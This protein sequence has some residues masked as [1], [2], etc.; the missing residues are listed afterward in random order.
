[1]TRRGRFSRNRLRTHLGPATPEARAQESPAHAPPQFPIYLKLLR[2]T[3]LPLTPTKRQRPSEGPRAQKREPSRT[4][5]QGRA[6]DTHLGHGHLKHDVLDRLGG[7]ARHGQQQHLHP[8][9]AGGP[10]LGK[11]QQ[12]SEAAAVTHDDGRQAACG[13]MRVTTTRPGGSQVSPGPSCPRSDSRP[14]KPTTP[15]HHSELTAAL[16]SEGRRDSS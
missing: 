13:D 8:R 2:V 4:G 10:G 14:S 1:M 16:V 3:T 5:S 15:A 11:V 12:D 6:A 9:V 7:R